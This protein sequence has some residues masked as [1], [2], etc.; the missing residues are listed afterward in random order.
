MSKLK[1]DE[2]RDIT[3]STTIPPAIPGLKPQIAQAW[4][5]FDG[6]GVVSIR[7]QYNVSSITDNGTGNYSV[8]FTT[9]ITDNYSA[10]TSASVNSAVINPPITTSAVNVLTKT[11][12]GS[13][14]DASIVCATVHSS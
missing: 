12:S 9:V 4:V 3:D 8:N 11:S 10:T 1:V 14:A 7:D 2:I 5:N 6:T 13:A